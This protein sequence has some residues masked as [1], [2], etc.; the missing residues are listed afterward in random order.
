VP[1]HAAKAYIG[2][3]YSSTYSFKLAARWRK[4]SASRP[5]RFTPGKR[6][7]GRMEWEENKQVQ[8]RR[9]WSAAREEE[10]ESTELRS[11]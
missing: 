11:R 7:A 4:E 2:V 6:A 10:G 3:R 8:R 5:R 1:V 9:S